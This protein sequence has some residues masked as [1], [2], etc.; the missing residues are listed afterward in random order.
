[1][2]PAAR[3]AAA[4]EILDEV[5]ASARPADRVVNAYLRSRRYIG[6]K[7]RRAI[8]E[9]VFA[10]LRHQARLDWHCRQAGLDAGRPRHRV[11]A[12]LA[13]VEGLE[14]EAVKAFF[15]GGTYSP[16]PLT[17]AE[18]QGLAALAG[19]AL[20]TEGQSPGERLEC[21]DW[22][23]PAFEAAFG[24]QAE[25]ELRAQQQVAPLDLRVNSLMGGRDQARQALAEAGIESEP[26]PLSP[27]GLRVE[28]RRAVTASP[29]FQSGLLEVQDEGAQLLAL[30]TDARPGMAVCDLCAGAG[31]KTLA[32]G[33]AMQGEG[34]LVAADSDA[35]RLAAGRPRLRRAGLGGVEERPLAELEDPW[36]A[37]EAESFD[38]VLIDAPC[39]GS[40][41]WRRAPD[42]RW[43]LTSERLEEFQAL[44]DGLLA[45]GAGLVRPGGRL[46]YATCSLLPQE[47]GARVA[48]FL[49]AN[50][51]FL[52]VPV[53]EV[54]TEVLGGAGP[55]DGPSLQLT[56]ARHGTDGFFVA[57]LE[58]RLKS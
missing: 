25:A 28:G 11:L 21:P 27:L 40:G 17:E 44:Q 6:S 50:P 3:I 52:Q 39:S 36:F 54:W 48:A 12:A 14:T 9:Q 57:I 10:L 8:T 37:A 55:E 41:T 19:Q 53:A 42:A 33:A 20:E 31:G 43:R 56:P 34:R 5:A 38:R 46:V 24:P 13:L 1:M 47:N 49:A 23:L 29:A 4:I 2:T 16:Q 30:L 35:R 32:L 7:D 22:L 45:A 26:T 51:A 58:R 18:A 15:D